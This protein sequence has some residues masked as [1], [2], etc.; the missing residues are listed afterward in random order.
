MRPHGAV[1]AHSEALMGLFLGPTDEATPF[2]E[3]SRKLLLLDHRLRPL[4]RMG[5]GVASKPQLED[6][7][8]TPCR[9]FG[10]LVLDEPFDFGARFGVRCCWQN[11]GTNYNGF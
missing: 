10:E 5:Y 2:G 8:P 4:N 3:V 11:L 7:L 1:Q 6:S 9:H